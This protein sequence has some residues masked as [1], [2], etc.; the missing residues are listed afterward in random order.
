VRRPPG[1]EPVGGDEGYRGNLDDGDQWPV[2]YAIKKWSP[3]VE[4]KVV[5]L[6]KAAAAS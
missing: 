4:K 1:E 3:V 6:V 5:E 2:S